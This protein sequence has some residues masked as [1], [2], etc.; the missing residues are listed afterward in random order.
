MI[1]TME[2]FNLEEGAA[3]YR[4]YPTSGLLFQAVSGCSLFDM[5][6]Y[7]GADYAPEL[8]ATLD[9]IVARANKVAAANGYGGLN[10][11]LLYYAVSM[12]RDEAVEY[13]LEHATDAMKRGDDYDEEVLSSQDVGAFKPTDIHRPCGAEMRTPLL[14]GV[15]WNRPALVNLLIRHGALATTAAKNPFSGVP[16]SWTALHVL[17]HSGHDDPRLV[18][19]LVDGGVSVDGVI[20]DTNHATA[21]AAPTEPPLLV[22]LQTDSFRVADAI[23]GL[24][25]DVNA[26]APAAGHLLL[27]RPTT[28][29]GH[30]IAS[31]ARNSIARLRWLLQLGPTA[32]MSTSTVDPVV[33]PSRR[34]TA[35]HRAAVAHGDVY[36][37]PGEP[38]GTPQAF[39]WDQVDWA[40]NREM[41]VELLTKFASPG[42]SGNSLSDTANETSE[43]T[44]EDS[45]P[46]SKPSRDPNP[47][48][49]DLVNA[50]ETSAGF[51]PLHLA[52]MAGNEAAVEL[53]LQHGARGDIPAAGDGT[54]RTAAQMARDMAGTGGTRGEVAA[55][56]R[57]NVL[58]TVGTDALN[59]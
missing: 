8:R 34:W 46:S 51:T 27:S 12:A 21:L 39:N 13:I 42:S 40:A 38:D 43:P 44:N 28:P 5:I 30:I 29:L 6:L 9:F 22:A 55:R 4:G 35:L 17:A 10:Q 25:A 16:S 20:P 14:E 2:K 53:L 18:Q 31:N 45:D 23:V 58:L 24:G 19:T 36:F 33:E 59:V 49:T 52:V 37:R 41:L 48:T 56:G 57:C 50:K 3:K 47:S 1:E 15:R 11:T 26:V 32:S 54:G 7:H